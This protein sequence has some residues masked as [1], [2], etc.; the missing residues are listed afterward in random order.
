MIKFR[1]VILALLAVAPALAQ[2]SNVTDAWGRAVTCTGAGPVTC[3][4]A[5]GLSLGADSVA[6]VLTTLA[7]M[8]P[9]GYQ[10]P[11][12]AQTTI[13]PEDAIGRFTAAEQ[14]AIQTA[15]LTDWSVA[16]WLT[17]FGANVV[18]DMSL[19]SIQ[20]GF[21]MLVTKN[22]LTSVRSAQIQNLSVA[23]P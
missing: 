5:D 14:Q 8:A 2:S 22:L 9:A 23:S 15:A 20:S 17:K 3:T 6:S 12:T 13:A 4:T 18:V 10:S 7:G 19:P 21:A 11:I 16:L 1:L